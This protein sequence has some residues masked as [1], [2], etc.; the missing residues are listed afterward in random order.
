MSGRKILSRAINPFRRGFTLIE[1]LVV[2][3][4]LGMLMALL[5]PAIG[6]VRER[7]RRLVCAT[8]IDQVAKALATYHSQNNCYPP[9]VGSCTTATASPKQFDLTPACQGPNWL[10]KLLP[11]IDEEAYFNQMMACID[12]NYNPCKD[13]AADDTQNPPRWVQVG[14]RT[15]PTFLC[16]SAE[17]IDTSNYFPA[18][19]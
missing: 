19:D 16:P 6:S 1:L 8:H 10:A 17:T 14:T 2:I 12:I 15:P 5:L 3:S 4:I 11:Q 7:G 13:C 9:G 18:A